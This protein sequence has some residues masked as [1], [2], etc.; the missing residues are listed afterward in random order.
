M[1]AFLGDLSTK[2]QQLDSQSAEAAQALIS[3]T[4]DMV[5]PFQELQNVNNEV[6]ADGFLDPR[7]LASVADIDARLETLSH[8]RQLTTNSLEFYSTIDIRAKTKLTK[9]R[10]PP[11][12][13]KAM[14][15]SY[16]DSMLLDQFL[17]LTRCSIERIQ[18]IERKFNL[19]KSQFGKWSVKNG[20]VIFNDE[21]IWQEW[22]D[23]SRSLLEL[24]ERQERIHREMV[25]RR[26]ADL[27]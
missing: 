12:K 17:P 15:D 11:L 2:A 13:T 20:T 27:K 5:K 18:V 26:E 9:L 24:A 10:L 8:L 14:V 1:K 3:I 23:S 25:A 6:A 16:A 4:S 22:N 19:L 7:I 21:F